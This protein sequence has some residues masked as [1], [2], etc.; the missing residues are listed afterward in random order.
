MMAENRKIIRT[1]VR[2]MLRDEIK[3][4]TDAEF[5]DDELDIYINKVLV[6]ISQRQPY[7]VIETVES[8]GT[9]EVDIST[10]NN[11]IGEKI[12]KV[13]YPTGNDPPTF[14]EFTIFGNT[15]RFIDTTPTSGEDIY[16]YCHE[17]HQVTES[18]S[19]LSADLEDV[20]IDGVVTEAAITWLNKM[21]DQIVPTSIQY[22]REWANERLILY[23]DGLNLLTKPKVWKF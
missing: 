17:V 5:A 22:Y 21:R 13:E 15:L 11:L 20:L 8:D 12:I 6:K 2:Q 23:R 7:E 9:K 10:I 14:E 4:S 19:T 3:E 16:L 18:S 1:I